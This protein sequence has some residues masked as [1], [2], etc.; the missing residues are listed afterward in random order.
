MAEVDRAAARTEEDREFAAISDAAIWEEAKDRLKISADAEVDNRK[1]AKEA[2]LFRE[3]QQWDKTPATSISQDEPE[4]TINLTDA[5]VTRVENN[6]RQQRPRA[7][8][9]PVG[10]GA[11][12][13]IAE[14]INGIIRHIDTRSEA[15]VAYDTAATC[16]LDGGVGYFRIIP[17]F[18][19]ARSFQKDLRILPIPNAF[20]VSMDPGAIMPSG[21]DQNW[22]IISEKMKRQEYKRRYPRA[23]NI[24]WNEYS[25]DEQRAEWE[26]AEAIRLAEYLRIREREE[27]L[28]LIRAA[29]GSEMTRYRSELPRRP[30]GYFELDYAVGRLKQHDAVIEGARDSVKRQVEWFRLNGLIVIERQQLPGQWIPVFRV[31]GRVKNIDGQV[32]R[33]GMVEPLMDPGRMVNYGEVAKIK[34]LGLTPKAPFTAFEGQ[35]DGHEDEWADANRKPIAVLV[36]KPVVIE[37]SQ[38]P[39]LL[40]APV[41]QQPAGIEQGFGEF[42]QGMRSNLMAVAG[43]PNEPGQDQQGVVVSGRALRRRQWL[44][45]QS[46]FHFYDNLTLAIAQCTRVEVEWIPFYYPEPGRVQRIIG[47]DSTPSMVT[48]NQRTQEAG[49][50]GQAIERIKNDLSVGRYDVVMDTGPGYETKRE[51]GAE[52]LIDLLRVGPLAEIIAKTGPD[53]VFRSIDHPY[54]QELA[55]RLMASNPEGL[56]KI[57]EGLSSRARSI[58]QALSNQVQALTQQNQQLQ[59]D[60]KAGIT[61]AHLAAA[62]KAHDTEVSAR[63][64][65][66]DTEVRAATALHVEE[67]R[68]GG[69]ILDTHA[70]AGHDA[71]AAQR[72]IEAGVNAENRSGG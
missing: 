15:S 51:E 12:I 20:T 71:A 67:I 11:D 57:M 30:D 64:K 4:L 23:A 10:E 3:G 8:V 49:P 29:D 22:C 26:D 69:K 56:Q 63:T 16:A 60:L 6:I 65:I 32:R 9:H 36:H 45:D 39:V 42:V 44:S 48:L 19:D 55:D 35:L 46:H 62:T 25:R 41:R 70:Q 33:K 40:P 66:H 37:T 21:S 58:V 34:R 31:E 13:E 2:I 14:V 27:K 50:N 72:M 38:G 7:K 53:L 28:Y 18:V 17:E 24:N 54:M 59:Q 5:L 1:R 68:A 52:N 61:K 47:E 43:M